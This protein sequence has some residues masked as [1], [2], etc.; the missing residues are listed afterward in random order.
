MEIY[1]VINR[2]DR[3]E[4][5]ECTFRV[6]GKRPEL[7]NAVDGSRRDAPAYRIAN[8]V[9]TVPLELPAY[10]S[11]FVILRNPTTEA[12]IAA[13]PA[14]EKL[15]LDMTGPWQV[16]FDPKWGGPKDPVTFTKLEDWTT[17]NEEGIKYFSGSATYRKTFGAPPPLTTR[18]SCLIWASCTNW[19][20]SGSTAKKS[21]SSGVRPWRVEITAALK[22][23]ANELEI[24][25]INAW[26]NR[27]VL[28]LSRAK[29]Q[30]LTDCSNE[31]VYYNVPRGKGPLHPPACWGRYGLW[32]SKGG[33]RDGRSHSTGRQ[34]G[35]CCTF[36]DED[37]ETLGNHCIGFCVAGA[38]GALCRRR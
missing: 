26:F 16:Q 25:V 2:R 27:L 1:F 31:H 15:V 11:A 9:T 3:A 10:G 8:G 23:G 4:R 32:R 34:Y 24:T 30:R 20:R 17:R 12:A 35:K 19:P 21:A 18:T 33:E 37:Y 22:P 29:E 28:D 38:C 14:V 13:V 5:V 36:G 7:W 6:A